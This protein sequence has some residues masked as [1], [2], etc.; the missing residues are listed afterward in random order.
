LKEAD[1]AFLETHY[2]PHS[3]PGRAQELFILVERFWER[4]ELPY[5]I[6]FTAGLAEKATQ[7]YKLFINWT[8]E[9]LKDTFWQRN[10]FKFK[11]LKPLDYSYITQPNPML[12]FSTPGLALN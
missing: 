8:N 11:Y 7:Y 1:M 4:F 10:A 6:Y 5:P 3:I 12:V 2:L 9:T